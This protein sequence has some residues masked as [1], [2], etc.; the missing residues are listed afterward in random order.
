MVLTAHTI[1]GVALAS[2]VPD[3]PLVGFAVGFL[4]HFVL[5]AMPH[6]D[7][8]LKSL[9]EDRHNPMN[10]DMVIGKEFFIDLLKISFDAI[11]GLLMSYLVFGLYL[12][13]SFLVILCGAVGA[14]MP[15]ALQFVYMK[16]RHE[17]FISLQRLHVFVDAN[18]TF[19]IR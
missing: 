1:T 17:P 15:D 11:F 5:D 7:Y 3:K 12:K 6:W 18:N 10:K 2:M 8:T 16:L 4:S 9:V 19:T 13:Y 14:M